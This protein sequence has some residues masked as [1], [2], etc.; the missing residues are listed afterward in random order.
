MATQQET[1][2]STKIKIKIL[3]EMS[4]P[5]KFCAASCAS[6]LINFSSIF[7]R[8]SMARGMLRLPAIMPKKMYCVKI[9]KYG[10]PE[11][12]RYSESALPKI[13]HNQVLIKVFAAGV[14]RPDVLQRKGLYEPPMGASKLPGLEV[15]GK[16]VLIGKNVRD[17]KIND[18]VCAC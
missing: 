7:L 14:N 16:A 17:F 12:L 10:G 13:N 9:I 3:G 18:K 2:A 4:F 8:K 5:D 6:F 1:L 15:S 11:S